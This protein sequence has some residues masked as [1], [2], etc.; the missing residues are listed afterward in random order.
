MNSVESKVERLDSTVSEIK[1]EMVSINHSITDQAVILKELKEVIVNQN[2]TL[3]NVFEVKVKVQG[4]EDELK[5][6]QD[7]YKIRKDKTDMFIKEGADFMSRFR[8]GLQVALFCFAIVQA[9]IGYNLYSASNTLEKTSADIRKVEME[10]ALV[11]GKVESVKDTVDKLL[12]DKL[13]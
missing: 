2:K 4:I 7:D 11:K 3:A 10:S 12:V 13:K 6:L 8:G 5:E 9:V 1:L